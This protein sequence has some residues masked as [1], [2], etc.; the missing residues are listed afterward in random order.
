MTKWRIVGTVSREPFTHEKFAKVS[1]LVEANGRKS[2]FDVK[3]FAPEMIAT[4]GRLQVGDGVT[5]EGE[6]MSE[7][8]KDGK[9]EVKDSRGKAIWAV[10]LKATS[11]TVTNARPAPKPAAPPDDMGD[12]GF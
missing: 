6:L 8:V 7:P 12:I 4:I 2:F 11:L 1:V 3:T 9:N 5:I 10:G